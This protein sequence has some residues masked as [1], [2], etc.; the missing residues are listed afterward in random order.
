MSLFSKLFGG[1]GS[2]SAPSAKATEYNGFSITPAPEKT[3]GG[4]RIS[5]R[6]EKEIGGETKTHHLIRADEI[7]SLEEAE[8]ASIAKAKVAIDQMGDGIFG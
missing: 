7:S 6:V 2:S 4:Y 1:G 3:S 8:A 5:A